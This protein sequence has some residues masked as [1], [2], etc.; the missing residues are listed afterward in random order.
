MQVKSGHMS[1]GQGHANEGQGY[2]S[3]GQ[4]PMSE[5]R[6]CV[7]IIHFDIGSSWMLFMNLTF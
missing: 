4:S 5:D 6:I 1:K 3:N 7:F 2:S